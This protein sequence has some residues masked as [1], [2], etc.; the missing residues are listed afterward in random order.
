[1][2]LVI[3]AETG[4][5][6]RTIRVHAANTHPHQLRCLQSHRHV[7]QAIPQFYQSTRWFAA[8]IDLFVVV[9]ED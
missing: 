1:M 5:A 4:S 6:H 3:I 8:I 9:Q 7:M 2:M